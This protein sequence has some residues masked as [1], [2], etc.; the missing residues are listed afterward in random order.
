[1][2]AILPW[3]LSGAGGAVL[4]PILSKILGGSGTSGL[5][6]GI[7]GGLAGGYG[8]GEFAGGG[9]AQLLGADGVMAHL[10]AFLNGGAGGGI[11]GAILGKVM[12][13][14]S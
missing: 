1:M 9:F 10:S 12:G 4:G 2:E 5:L 6:G 14:N 13:G 8:L 3:I 7:V 11:L